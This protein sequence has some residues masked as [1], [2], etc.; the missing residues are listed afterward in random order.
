MME[1]C[2]VQID[3]KAALLDAERTLGRWVPVSLIRTSGP[4]TRNPKP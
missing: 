2:V 1:C 4:S 3:A